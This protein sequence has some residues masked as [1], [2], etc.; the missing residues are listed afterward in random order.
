[1]AI[2]P[3]VLAWVFY[4]PGWGCWL[5]PHCGP[6]VLPTRS[7]LQLVQGKLAFSWLRQQALAAALL[8]S[9]PGQQ[10]WCSWLAQ[11]T[12]LNFLQ[13]SSALPAD[14]AA[15]W[16]ALQVPYVVQPAFCAL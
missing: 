1:M 16:H 11:Q 15:A 9:H 10:R 3:L 7:G 6:A 12:A 13:H 2:I 4:L 5:A 14:L 8:A